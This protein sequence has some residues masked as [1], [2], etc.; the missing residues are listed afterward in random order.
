MKGD[1]AKLTAKPQRAD[2][3]LCLIGIVALLFECPVA[4]AGPLDLDPTFNKGS[5]KVVTSFQLHPEA[6]AVALQKKDGKIIAVGHADNGDPTGE[7]FA[8]VRYNPD[9]SIDKAFGTDNNGRVSTD[10]GL[11]DS[12]YGVVIQPDGKIVVAGDVVDLDVI[13]PYAPKSGDFALARYNSD[14]TLDT[15]FGKSGRVQT[16]FGAYESATGR[17]IATRRK[18]RGRWSPAA[19]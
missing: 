6:L 4:A 17:R 14:G 10:F 12:A 2:R 18:N 8:L 11:E 1:V 3:A 5:G 16:D 13:D 7:D 19:K 9:G 15:S